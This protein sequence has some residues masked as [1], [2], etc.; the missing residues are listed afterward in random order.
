MKNAVSFVASR[1]GRPVS[2]GG[3]E[4]RPSLAKPA[5]KQC[6]EKTLQ[7][8]LQTSEPKCVSRCNPLADRTGRSE[9][10]AVVSRVCVL[11]LLPL[12]EAGCFRSLEL[13]EY[14][15]LLPPSIPQ[16]L[17]GSSCGCVYFF[18]SLAA[19]DQLIILRLL[20]LQQ[21]VSERA[22]RLWVAPG[23]VGD[24]R[25]SLQRLVAFHVLQPILPPS[26][27]N[28]ASKNSN[29]QPMQ[30]ALSRPF[31]ETLLQLILEGPVHHSLP[32][33]ESPPREAF[34]SRAVLSMHS[35]RCWDK[36]LRF[37]VGVRDGARGPASSAGEKEPSA[38]LVK[39]RTPRCLA[40]ST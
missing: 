8:R 24:L 39:A 29:P 9:V 19:F 13:S 17:M 25:R 15:A 22:M 14:M 11:T 4:A 20:F 35:R 37:I 3:S 12:C 16:A 6:G 31:K 34:P 21:C 27:A 28:A 23:S 30:Y 1:Q 10:A 38:D 40:C 7:L 26:A 33:L 2:S 32:F 36:L 18:N 5:P